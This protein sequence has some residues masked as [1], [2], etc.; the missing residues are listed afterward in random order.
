MMIKREIIYLLIVIVL[1]VIIL[2]GGMM[3]ENLNIAPGGN[4]TIGGVNQLIPRRTIIAYY[5]ENGVMGEPP[6]GWAICDGQNNT[7]DLRGRFLRMY[8]DGLGTFNSWGGL[9]VSG[10]TTVDYAREL[11]GRNRANSNSWIL[12]HRIGDR[13][14]T[15]A[16]EL[17]VDELPPHNHG[18]GLFAGSNSTKWN[19]GDHAAP[20]QTQ[21]NNYPALNSQNTGSGFGHNNQP[22]YF[23]LVFLMKL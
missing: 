12:K 23:V 10:K 2:R 7:P 21:V 13:A 6:S 11:A 1:A 17:N 20:L 22:P 3:R 16:S 8:S 18:L 19:K 4:L 15:D 5:P 14:G 9:E